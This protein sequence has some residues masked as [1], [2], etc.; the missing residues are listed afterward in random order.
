MNHDLKPDITELMGSLDE[1]ADL[2]P[3]T[4]G[5][6]LL[7]VRRRARRRARLRTGVTAVAGIVA[8]AAVGSA[9][10]QGLAV[11][12]SGVTAGPSATQSAPVQP[13]APTPSPTRDWM[14]YNGEPHPMG[15]VIDT[16]M[17]FQRG[18]L[19]IWMQDGEDGPQVT[20]G[21]R[22]ASGDL[23]VVSASSGMDRS[24]GTTKGFHAGVDAFRSG[25][26]PYAWGAMGY[27]VGDVDR[28]TLRVDG[29]LKTAQV[30]AWSENPDVKLWWS[31]GPEAERWDSKAEPI[32]EYTDLVAYDASGTVVARKPDGDISG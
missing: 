4:L 29:K 20:I 27:V 19:A 16:T 9:A 10:V 28:V 8:A 5:A 24:G 1:A 31:I 22:N 2:A 25:D 6:S 3:A 15:K 17:P 13:A 11:R 14:Q 12:S 26:V 23:E 7:D 30:A 21:A 18:T 32:E